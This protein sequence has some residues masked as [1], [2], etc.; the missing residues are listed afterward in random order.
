[1]PTATQFAHSITLDHIVLRKEEDSA[2]RRE[3]FS[4]VVL[5]IF[6]RWL[7]SYAAES[8]DAE[9][10]RMSLERFLGPQVEPQHIY[11]DNAPE[12][13]KA[14]EDKGWSG[15]HD[16]STPNRPATNGIAEHAVRQCKEGTSAVLLQGGFQPTWWA[17]AMSYYTFVHNIADKLSD[18]K[19]PYEKRFGVK[20]SGPLYPFGCEITYKPSSPVVKQQMHPLGSKVLRGVF[21]GYKQRMGGRLEWR[22]LRR[23]LGGLREGRARWQHLRPH[24]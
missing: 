9:S 1:M 17:D 6:T 19:T 2:R 7:Q 22:S 4:C 8:K 10:T 13:I 20:F 14:V 16:T 3:R 21:L 23:R 15:R 5:D 24:H 18:G 11:S 12:I